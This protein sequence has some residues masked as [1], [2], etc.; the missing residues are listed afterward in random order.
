[1]KSLKQLSIES[2]IESLD[3]DPDGIFKINLPETVREQIYND[4]AKRKPDPGDQILEQ[5]RH[6]KPVLSKRQRNAMFGEAINE[7]MIK[8]MRGEEVYLHTVWKVMDF[9]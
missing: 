9:Q 3:Y 7:K 1:M 4:I 6:D 5:L 2:I 8:V